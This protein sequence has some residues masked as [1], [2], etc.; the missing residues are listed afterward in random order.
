M[1]DQS[2]G[3]GSREADAPTAL[4][5]C[6]NLMF[7]VQLQNMARKAGFQHRN[8]RP[9][10]LLPSAA[11]LVVDLASQG[12]WQGA[13]QEAAANGTPVIAFGPHT[14]SEARRL[15]KAAGASRVLANSNLSRDLPAILLALRQAGRTPPAGE[16]EE[17]GH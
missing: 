12:G 13:I 5:L 16:G 6:T 15:A 4:L 14:D 3:T 1:T 10:A 11:V 8:A 9:G 2:A 17:G 7:L